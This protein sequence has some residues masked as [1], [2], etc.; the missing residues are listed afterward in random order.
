MW[1]PAER[2]VCHFLILYYLRPKG[3]SPAL[4]RYCFPSLKGLSCSF[5]SLLSRTTSWGS[6]KGFEIGQI[7]EGRSRKTITLSFK[8]WLRALE[9]LSL[10]VVSPWDPPP[11]VNIFS[12]PQKGFCRWKKW[13]IFCHKKVVILTFVTKKWLFFF[14]ASPIR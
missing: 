10:S 13:L 9:R 1:A 14:K 5:S 8:L 2:P 3:V 11:G 4:V 6:L 12:T 7:Q